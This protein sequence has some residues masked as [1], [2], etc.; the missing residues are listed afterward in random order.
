MAWMESIGCV[1]CAAND[2]SS[3]AAAVVEPYLLSKNTGTKSKSSKRGRGL[4]FVSKR[5][6]VKEEF[7][8]VVTV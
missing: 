6:D 7:R 8:V 3:A 1:S 5:K 4:K 2:S